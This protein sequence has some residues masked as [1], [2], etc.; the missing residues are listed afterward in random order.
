[1]SLSFDCIFCLG[2]VKAWEGEQKL[3]PD[4]CPWAPGISWL[5]SNIFD[6]V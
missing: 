2:I 4:V 6:D 5:V 3:N 1:M